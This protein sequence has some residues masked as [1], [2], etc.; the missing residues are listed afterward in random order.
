M[1]K[2]RKHVFDLLF[3][4]ALFF[5]FAATSLLVVMIG[6]NVYRGTV[7]TMERT[8]A[9]RTSL[10]YIAE[11]LRQ[12]DNEGAAEVGD[13]A[14][15]PALVITQ[16]HSGVTLQTYIY[17]YNGYLT[18]LLATENTPLQPELGQAV[19]AL[20]GFYIEEDNN[21]FTVTTVGEDGSEH[22]LCIYVHAA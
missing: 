18:E 3:S 15:L 1:G 4:L 5:V 7:N 19:L 16:Q 22:S 6:A 14:G 11:K 13:I 9:S 8:F 10:S 2:A 17:Y 12:N 21:L 20:G